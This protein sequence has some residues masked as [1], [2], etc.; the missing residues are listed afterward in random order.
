MAEPAKNNIKTKPEEFI[1]FHKALMSNAPADYVPWYFPV[2]QHNKDP[3]A[4]AI[5]ARAPVGE[6]SRY[7]WKAQHARLSYEEALDRL[8][9]GYN[10]GI[11][12]RL[13]DPLCIIDIDCFC[14]V[15][16]MPNSLIV[17][18][19]KGIGLHGFFWWKDT[20]PKLNIPT[21]S[22][23]EVRASDQY[24]V[25]SGSYCTTYPEDVK[26]ERM[27]EEIETEVLKCT[28]LGNY[29]VKNAISPSNIDYEGLPDF[30]KN[31]KEPE[32]TAPKI[33]TTTW[34]EVASD[35]IHRTAFNKLKITDIFPEPVIGRVKHPLHTSS[36]EKNFSISGDLAHCWRHEVSLNALQYLVVKSGYM[37]C[38]DAG[39]AH[40]GSGAG[41]SKVKG[42]GGALF[43]AWLQAKKD[44]LIPL[45]DPIP[46]K[47]MLYIAIK[48]GLIKK[49]PRAYYNSVLKIVEANY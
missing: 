10:V 35:S 15:Q 20:R 45:D 4:F 12:A 6:K 23:G 8:E 25:C 19:R 31:K 40:K 21:E 43:Y 38:V 33:E 1:T 39:T 30:F 28:D 48:H 27:P 18:S 41:A 9:K 36:T 7:S 46:E 2:S 37:S 47:A 34:K 44:N 11:S 49:L 16:D 24:V 3:D 32:E 29:V 5:G 13:N 42:N 22:F 14:F 26:N 17:R